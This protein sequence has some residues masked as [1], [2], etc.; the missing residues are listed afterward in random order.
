MRE[1]V[2][3]CNCNIVKGILGYLGINLVL[4]GQ[5]NIVFMFTTLGAF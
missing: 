1:F 5:K 3:S 4:L 2:L